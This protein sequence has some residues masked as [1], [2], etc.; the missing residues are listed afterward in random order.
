MNAIC[1]F[2][3]VMGSLLIAACNTTRVAY[4][5]PKQ[6]GNY[7]KIR[8]VTLSHC[9][10]THIYVDQYNNSRK[11]F[12]IFYS[13]SIVK[14]STTTYDGNKKPQYLTTVFAT[15]D[16]ER[17]KPFDSLD[18]EIFGKIDSII[19][20]KNKIV[21]PL[22]RRHYIGYLRDTLTVTPKR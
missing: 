7:Y 18:S 4:T 13:G 6:G 3:L 15:E 1:T 16:K 2:I 8:V 9:G 20:T 21:Y 5:S 11:T 19:A 10:C 22:L 14:K 12:Q 17:A